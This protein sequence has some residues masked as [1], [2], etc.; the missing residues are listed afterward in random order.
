[1]TP[2]NRDVGTFYRYMGW[3]SNL[4]RLHHGWRRELENVDHLEPVDR[5]KRPFQC[6]NFTVLK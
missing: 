4:T 3:G 2:Q 5:R 1:M 6:L